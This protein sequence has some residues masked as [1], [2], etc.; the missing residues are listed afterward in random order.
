MLQEG[1]CVEIVC[2]CRS[3]SVKILWACGVKSFESRDPGIQYKPADA[4]LTIIQNMSLYSC[5]GGGG[6]GAILRLKRRPPT[7]LRTGRCLGRKV[8]GNVV[9]SDVDGSVQVV[10]VLVH[11]PSHR[12]LGPSSLQ[13]ARWLFSKHAAH[14]IP[15]HPHS[16]NLS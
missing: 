4:Y 5:R 15:C 9:V 8:C 14:R 2:V 11:Q 10:C 7:F 6:G 13:C 16:L 12:P 3:V 1:S